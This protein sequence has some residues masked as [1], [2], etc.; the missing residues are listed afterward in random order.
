MQLSLVKTQH[1]NDTAVQ[2]T[3][4]QYSVMTHSGVAGALCVQLACVFPG[5]RYI[6]SVSGIRS[7][8][9]YRWQNWNLLCLFHYGFSDS[10]MYSRY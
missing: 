7:R 2:D 10:I 1:Y 3:A 9:V 8:I 6:F 5:L 4:V